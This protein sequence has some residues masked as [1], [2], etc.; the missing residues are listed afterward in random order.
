MGLIRVNLS[1]WRGAVDNLEHAIERDPRHANALYQLGF[2]AE[3]RGNLQEAVSYYR[4]A[5]SARPGHVGAQQRLEQLLDRFVSNDP[6]AKTRTDSPITGAREQ[7]YTRE[8]SRQAAADAHGRTDRDLRARPPGGEAESQPRL[9]QQPSRSSGPATSTNSPVVGVVRRLQAR[10]EPVGWIPMLNWTVWSFLVER[11]DEAG[12]PLPNPLPPIAVQMRGFHFDG[13]I[14]EGDVVEVVTGGRHPG[15]LV[16]AKN[17]YNRTRNSSIRAR[18]G[19][20]IQLVKIASVLTILFT[21]IILYWI[22]SSSCNSPVYWQL[23]GPVTSLCD[24]LYY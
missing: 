2:I 14:Y 15:D 18:V 8:A 24:A 22:F 4:K 17:V 7:D 23:P 16:H 21:L 6:P 10:A 12:N 11:T 3:H 13:A 9:S 19:P 1:D 20:A 5:Q